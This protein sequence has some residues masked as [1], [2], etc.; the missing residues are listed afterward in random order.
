M[1]NGCEGL[2]RN[3]LTIAAGGSLIT[4]IGGGAGS[5]GFY[6]STYPLDIGVYGTGEAGGGFDFGLSAKAGLQSGELSGTGTN[7]NAAYTPV[8]GTVSFDSNGNVNGFSLGGAIR[9]GG[10]LTHTRT[11]AISIRE[12][13]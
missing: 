7:L 8:A 11:G 3:S 12:L 6:F 1:L 5:L 13:F 10:S 2:S 4:P 9:A